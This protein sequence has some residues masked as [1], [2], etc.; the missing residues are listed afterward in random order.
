MLAG[1]SLE[2]V[3]VSLLGALQY[4]AGSEHFYK[5]LFRAG[6]LW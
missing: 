6:I 5:N 2:N 3:D 4:R 1:A